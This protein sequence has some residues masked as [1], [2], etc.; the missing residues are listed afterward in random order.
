MSEI[1]F[2]TKLLSERSLVNDSMRWCPISIRSKCLPGSWI[3]LQQQVEISLHLNTLSNVMIQSWPVLVLIPYCCM[4][5]REVT[6]TNFIVSYPPSNKFEASMLTITPSMRLRLIWIVTLFLIDK[7]VDILFPLSIANW[8]N[9]LI[10]EF[11]SI[12]FMV[13]N[14]TFNNHQLYFSNIVAVSYI[15]GGNRRTWRKPPTCCKS[16]TNLL[17]HIMLYLVH[18]SMNRVRT[19]NVSGDSNWLH[20]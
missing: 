2:Q 9:T 5:F 10:S 7:I 15:G 18:L 19:H 3:F 6:N 14:A 16:L 12:W 4:L 17:Y 1:I 11:F 13:L 8:V 20:R